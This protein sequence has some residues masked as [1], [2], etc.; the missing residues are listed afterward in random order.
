MGSSDLIEIRIQLDWGILR[1][2]ANRSQAYASNSHIFIM[3][4][5]GTSLVLL[6][7][8]IVFLRNQ[9]RPI[10]ALA[11]AAKSFGKGRDIDFK[12]RGAQEIREA[13]LA[14]IEMRRRIERAIEQRTAM[15]NGVS[16]DLRTILTRF[17]LS[18]EVIEDSAELE[19]LKKDVDE[20]SRMLEAYLAF[21]R[22]E[23]AEQAVATD[24][25]RLLDELKADSERHGHQTSI[26][27]AGN[28]IAIVR[29]DSF[30]RCLANLVANAARHG[31]RIAITATHDERW[32]S[33]SIDDDGPGIPAERR[34]D[35]FKP[36]V[37]LDEARNVDEGGSGLGLAIARDI[38]RAHG[39]DVLL[40]DSPL[41]GLRA[42]VRVPA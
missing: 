31:S 37:R 33:V 32:L 23:V 18:L 38:A 28:P 8:A 19:A 15:L 30:K 29:Q 4:M 42:T 35:V 36:F 16:H 13:G 1:V 10:L 34:E 7:V 6:G 3:W 11:D 17:R 2:I 40:S 12:P 20:M 21:A 5:I 26:T 39:G 22:G 27:L 24:I 9:I 41:G 14:F 25:G